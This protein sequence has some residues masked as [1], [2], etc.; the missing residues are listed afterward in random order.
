MKKSVF[1]FLMTVAFAGLLSAQGYKISVRVSGWA[2]T[3]VLLGSYYGKYQNVIDT[4]QF[5]KNGRA[6][7]ESTDTVG[8]GIYF[9]IMPDKKYFE[10]ILDKDRVLN[11]E[12]DTSDLI[13]NIKTKGSEDNALFF[14]YQKYISEQGKIMEGL[15]KNLKRFK[16]AGQ[17]DSVK[18]L[19]SKMEEIN[20][21]VTDYKLAFIKDHPKSFV[22]VI[23]SSS[24]EPEVPDAPVLSN[25]R[26]DSLF[27]Y[28]YFRAH[29]WDDIDLTDDRLLR[30]PI[31]HSKLDQYINK[32]VPQIP[33]TLMAECDMLIER[34]RPSKEMFKYIVWFLTHQYETSQVMGMDA[35][36]VYLV[37]KVYAKDEAFWISE[38]VKS[39]ILKAAEKKRPN[40]IGKVAPE[41]ILIDTNNRLVS[42]HSIPA[43][44]TIVYF[45]D[46][47][48]GHCAKETPKLVKYYNEVKD[49]LNIRIFAVCSDTSLTRWKKTLHEK[50]MDDFINV[51]GT[52]SAQGNFHDLYDIFSTPV[53]YL[54]DHRKRIIA[55]KLPVDQI[56]SFL[57][58]Y[59]RR[60][61]FTD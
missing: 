9:V 43:A 2:D 44:F 16:D 32:V 7:F 18:A 1:V 52:R 22:S 30:T 3:T 46:P 60:P 55:K 29:F 17:T 49:T 34:A 38:K 19:E 39:N 37:D 27:Q 42:L 54:L 20:K 10:F 8:G 50:K 33:D 61:L 40:L 12:T 56:G 58:F 53:V 21:S 41:L 14:A 47:E 15:G 35:V 28:K 36:F 24:R 57:E 45:W 13:A 26:K 4:A 48:C 25:G 6:V 23:F 59:R 31:L 11:F 5:D 51:N